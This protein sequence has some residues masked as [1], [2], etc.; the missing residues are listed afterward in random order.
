MTLVK[1]AQI[2]KDVRCLWGKRHFYKSRGVANVLL[3]R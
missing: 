2:A 3:I 1:S